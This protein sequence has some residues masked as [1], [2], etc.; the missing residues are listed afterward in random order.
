[1]TELNSWRLHVFGKPRLV[2]P[3]GAAVRCDGKALALLAYLAV[4]GATTRSRLARLLWP[5][6]PEPAARNNLVTLLRRMHT[7]YGCE[8]VR[9]QERLSLH[10]VRADVEAFG[11]AQGPSRPDGLPVGALLDGV[12]FDALH[13]LSEWLV[14]A[15]ERFDGRRAAVVTAA[16]GVAEADGALDDA[17]AYAEALLSLDPLDEEA[18]RALMRVRYRQGDR[19]A[20]LR[21]Y[22]RCKDTLSR[23]LGA[24]PSDVTVRLAREID[25]GGG[26]R[27][28]AAA[29]LPVA[30]L[31]P[32]RLLGREDAWA[33]LEDAW[34][35]GKQM[36]ITGDPGAGKTRLAQDFLRSKGEWLYLPSRPGD[37]VVPFAAA[38]RN[39][40][41]RLAA[42]PDARLPDW[43]RVELSRVLP[44]LRGGHEP[45]P[46]T[47]EADRRTFFQAHLEMAR[48]TRSTQLATLNDDVQY[49]DDA[50]I[51]LGAFMF[52]NAP[53]PSQA[54]SPPRFVVVYRRGELRPAQQAAVD[55]LVAAGLAVLV[56]LPPLPREAVAGLLD[57][58]G[59]RELARGAGVSLDELAVSLLRASGG[60]PQ[61]VL[62]AVRHAMEGGDARALLDPAWTARGFVSLLE[63]RLTQLSPGAL[64]VARAAA[65]LRVDYTLEQVADVLG[66]PLLDAAVAWDELDAAQIVA[67]D[68]FSHDLVAEATLEAIPV[69]VRRLLH[70]AA[71]RVLARDG[72]PPARVARLWL[73]GGDARQAAPLWMAAARAAVETLRPAEAAGFY[74]AAAD[75]F[76]AAGERV[77]AEIAWQAAERAQVSE[78]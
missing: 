35:S 23:L 70:R 15:R 45:P 65:V 71:A 49:Y 77:L 48:L 42:A 1:M 68:A 16:L 19:P 21:A 52:A 46:L 27:G 78:G 4:E 54:S 40:R 33:A 57:D 50:T 17:V 56:D 9:G 37:Q 64:D 32:P 55:R 7:A 12:E 76:E 69:T 25:R 29:R 66:V 14:A 75:A 31:R 24:E 28:A 6:T 2:T 47:A 60:N 30:V 62:E 18:W 3:G 20:A 63:R 38:A 73:E 74:A 10:A 22:H 43:V 59:V 8:L 51:E 72:A 41:A 44:E 36:F 67:G 61:Y 53:A 39:A 11:D 5:D 58:L 34:A 13:D 26:P